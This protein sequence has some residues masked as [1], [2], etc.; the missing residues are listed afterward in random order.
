[1][2]LILYFSDDYNIPIEI[3]ILVH[4]LAD[5]HLDVVPDFKVDQVTEM[6]LI[7]S[8]RTFDCEQFVQRRAQKVCSEFELEFLHC[9]D[10]DIKLNYVTFT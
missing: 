4:T 5:Q 9:Q 6:Q 2:F 3:P 1:M 8:Q 7:V 10:Y